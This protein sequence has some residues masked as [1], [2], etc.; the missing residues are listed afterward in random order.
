MPTDRSYGSDFV[1]DAPSRTEA[2]DNDLSFGLVGN[3]PMVAHSQS[4]CR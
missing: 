3:H 2:G 4:Q 1:Q